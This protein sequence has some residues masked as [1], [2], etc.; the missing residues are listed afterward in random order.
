MVSADSAH[1]KQFQAILDIDNRRGAAVVA[2]GTTYCQHV[3]Q[4]YTLI[5]LPLDGAT[6]GVL[7]QLLLTTRKPLTRCCMRLVFVHFY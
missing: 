3:R 2:G 6:G 7:R 5:P 1:C 4:G